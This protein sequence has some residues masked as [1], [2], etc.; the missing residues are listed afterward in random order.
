MK[1]SV[2]NMRTKKHISVI[3]TIILCVMIVACS[4]EQSRDR[5]EEQEK[6][7]TAKT[8]SQQSKS[9]PQP[10]AT[11][12]IYRYDDFPEAKAEQLKNELQEVYPSV[13]LVKTSIPLPKECYY[14]PRDRYKG[15]G[16]LDDLMKFRNGGYALG[17]TRKIIYDKNEISP[18]F[19]VFGISY[20][21]GRVSV[22]SSLRPRTL[23][24]LSDNDM[25]ELMLHELGHAF[26]LPHCKDE[27]CMMVDAEHGYKF[28]QTQSFCNDCKKYLNSK[29]WIL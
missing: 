26:G 16:L 3:A 11:I 13:I 4:G 22:I 17:L 9:V 7:V 23:K 21:G 15:T 19:G 28:A 6:Q 8:T 20:I 24:P 27:R 18:T 1:T 5:Q 14:K 29:G 2:H 12:Y 25:Q 10:I